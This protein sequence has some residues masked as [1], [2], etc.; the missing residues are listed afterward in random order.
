M[1]QITLNDI[2]QVI[3]KEQERWDKN[4]RAK[5]CVPMS[6]AKAVYRFLP[7]KKDKQQKGNL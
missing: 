6:I 1:K 7:Q 4:A 2:Y 3:I 5:G